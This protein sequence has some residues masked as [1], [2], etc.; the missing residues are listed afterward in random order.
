MSWSV[1]A[2]LLGLLGAG[3]EID[4]KYPGGNIVV[5]G[6]ANDVVRLKTDLRDTAGW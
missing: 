3:I 5:D 2:A 1:A 6:I 4:A